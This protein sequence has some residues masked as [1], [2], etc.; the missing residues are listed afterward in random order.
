[1]SLQKRKIS[2][3]PVADFDRYKDIRST[4]LDEFNLKCNQLSDANWTPV[5]DVQITPNTDGYSSG[6]DKLF[7]FHQ[8]WTLTSQEEGGLPIGRNG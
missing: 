1:M 4:D 7:V 3:L 5:H 6:L 2:D 8:Q